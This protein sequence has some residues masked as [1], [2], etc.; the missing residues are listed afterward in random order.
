MKKWMTALGA[1]GLAVVVGLLVRR[2]AQD[3]SD[4]ARLWRS[5]TDDPDSDGAGT[6]TA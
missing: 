2:M 3:L 4:N 5:V 1:V 6:T